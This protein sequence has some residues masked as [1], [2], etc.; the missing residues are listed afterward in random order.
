MRP[1]AIYGPGD[2]EGKLI[3]QTIIKALKKEDVSL[4]AGEQKRDYIYIDDVVEGCLKA[5]IYPEAIGQTINLGTGKEYSIKEVVTKCLALM[6]N[7]IK[8]RFG[9]I[10]YRENEM[11]N[12]RADTAK[13]KE[14]LGWVFKVEIEEGLKKMIEWYGTRETA[15]LSGDNS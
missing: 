9:V 8:P 5:A 15:R 4:T 12:L 11:F 13:A 7:P 10:P 3:T 6:G 1:F 2:R 14:I